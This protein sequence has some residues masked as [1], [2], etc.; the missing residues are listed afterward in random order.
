MVIESL[1]NPFFLDSAK[2]DWEFMKDLLLASLHLFAVLLIPPSP[3][4]CHATNSCTQ[5]FWYLSEMS[6]YSKATNP[7]SVTCQCR[8]QPGAK[9]MHL[10]V[11]KM[12]YTS[13]FHS[14]KSCLPQ[15]V[16]K[17][18]IPINEM[19]RIWL[20]NAYKLAVSLWHFD[21]LNTHAYV[22]SLWLS[23]MHARE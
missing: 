7:N 20:L 6:L 11:K 18:Y 23:G 13:E 22:R 8:P 1:E 16:K 17:S 2:L 10:I 3:P 12:W 19:R 9:R 15:V 14:V 21:S 4:H 5:V